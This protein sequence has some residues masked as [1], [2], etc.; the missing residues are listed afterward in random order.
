MKRGSKSS[1]NNGKPSVA[2]AVPVVVLLMATRVNIYAKQIRG[3]FATFIPPVLAYIR[4]SAARTSTA[5]P[6]E[7]FYIQNGLGTSVADISP[8]ISMF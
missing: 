1:M 3:I 7:R 4:P 5:S 2:V 8:I 6:F